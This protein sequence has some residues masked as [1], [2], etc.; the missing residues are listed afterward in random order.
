MTAPSATQVV[1][2]EP[3][4]AHVDD[5]H[6]YQGDEVELSDDQLERLRAAGARF[7]NDEQEAV[8]N[9]EQE[10]VDP[11]ADSPTTPSVAEQEQKPKSKPS[12]DTAAAK[13]GSG[14]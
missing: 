3:E 5:V 13:S 10:T 11:P 7:E 1:L 12:V 4:E 2:A 9:D 6:L 14:M 8:E